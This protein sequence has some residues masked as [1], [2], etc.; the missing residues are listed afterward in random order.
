MRAPL[1]L[2]PIVS[3]QQQK[4]EASTSLKVLSVC[5]IRNEV[6]INKLTW[7]GSSCVTC[8]RLKFAACPMNTRQAELRSVQQQ[9]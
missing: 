5:K 6:Q 1:T 2:Q 8:R 7:Q 9:E 4:C 3:A